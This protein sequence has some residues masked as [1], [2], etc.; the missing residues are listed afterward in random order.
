MLAT[1]RIL[2]GIFLL[3]AALAGVYDAT[4][5]MAADRLV[6]ASLLEHWSNIAPS[7]LAAA[8][9]AV[10]RS[11]GAPVW[12]QGIARVLQLPAWSVFAGI[13][14]LCAYSGRRRRRVNVF[15]N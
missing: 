1:F 2:A 15:A 9:G 10:R 8:Q 14:L 11:A 13:G 5:S 7:V 6:M 12:D 4:R 3:I